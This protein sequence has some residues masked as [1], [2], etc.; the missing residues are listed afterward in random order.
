MSAPL[1]SQVTDEA[2]G[3]SLIRTEDSNIFSLTQKGKDGKRYKVRILDQQ[4]NHIK[5][6]EWVLDERVSQMAVAREAL[7]NALA[8]TI[9]FSFVVQAS[10]VEERR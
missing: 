10:Y 8:A 3:C 6:N 7:R 4:L 5:W 1:N 2:L 9:F